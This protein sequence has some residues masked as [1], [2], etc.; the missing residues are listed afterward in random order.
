[1]G[2]LDSLLGRSRTARPAKQDRLFAMTTANVALSTEHGIE[3]TG[4]AGIVFQPQATSDFTRIAA[5]GRL[6]QQLQSGA[7]R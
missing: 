7:V 6:E 5:L 1:M 3:T 2:F 4:R